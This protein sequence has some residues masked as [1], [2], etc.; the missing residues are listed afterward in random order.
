M[1]MS[2]GTGVP[3]DINIL[4]QGLVILFVAAPTLIR[5]LMGRR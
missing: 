1:I 4:L 3:L 5:N 2:R